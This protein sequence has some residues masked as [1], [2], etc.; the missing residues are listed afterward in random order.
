MTKTAFLAELQR[1]LKAMPE[2]EVIAAIAY[3]DEYLSEAGPENEET[4]IAQLGSPAQ[5]AAGIMGDY[6]YAD[7]TGEDITT[8]KGLSALWI[9]VIG[10]IVGPLALPLAL[11]LI[12]LIFS[13]LI[14][15][16]SLIFSLFATAVA[17]LVSGVV[18]LATGLYTLFISF[19]TGV[20]TIGTGLVFM[21]MGAALMLIMIWA[22]KHIV[23]GIAAGSA[24]LLRRWNNRNGVA[25]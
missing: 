4:A 23:N 19:A 17:L 21:A 7:T 2:S 22:T 24:K 5:V 8:G 20:V 1:K 10:L 3:Y 16:L 9:V 6:V 11:V 14:A 25:S 13:L 15:A 18:Y 12:A